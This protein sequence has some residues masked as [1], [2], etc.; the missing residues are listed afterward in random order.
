MTRVVGSHN[1]REFIANPAEALR[2]GRRLDAMLASALPQRPKGVMRASHGVF[3]A[4]DD[5]RRLIAAR[6]VTKAL[7]VPT[8]PPASAAA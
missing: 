4:L 7:G 6:R 3:N 1:R 8:I 2:I 5:E